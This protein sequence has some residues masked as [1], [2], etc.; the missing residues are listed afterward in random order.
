MNQTS[1]WLVLF[2]VAFASLP[3]LVKWVQ[4]R[5]GLGKVP[6]DGGTR[7]ISSLALSPQQ[8]VV[9]VEVLHGQTRTRLVLGVTPQSISCLHVMPT[10]GDS[11]ALAVEPVLT[12]DFPSR[13][14]E[15]QR[16]AS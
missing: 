14:D 7:L 11:T 15:H 1:F 9:T 2:V 13:L 5:T 16:I 12:P 4:R 8:R 3:W 6:Q 10:S